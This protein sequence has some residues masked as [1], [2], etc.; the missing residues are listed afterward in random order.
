MVLGLQNLVARRV[1]AMQ[2]PLHDLRRDEDVHRETTLSAIDHSLGIGAL[3]VVFG[4][5][6]TRC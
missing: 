4:I 1:D 6:E 5:P 2:R 3:A